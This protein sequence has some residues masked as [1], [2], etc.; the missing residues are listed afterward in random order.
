[1]F[2]QT[3]AKKNCDYCR[4]FESVF[5]ILFSPF[6]AVPGCGL[7]EVADGR[8]RRCPISGSCGIYFVEFVGNIPAILF[9]FAI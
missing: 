5:S 9:K 4:F 3:V 6:I 1:M 2:F 8:F 7:N